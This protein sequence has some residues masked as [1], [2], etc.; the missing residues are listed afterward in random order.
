MDNTSCEQK[1]VSWALLQPLH[2]QP[3]TWTILKTH[4][5]PIIKN[6]C[7][8]CTRYINNIFNSYTGE[9][10]KLN[11]Y[12]T[13]QNM[14]HDLIKFKH[15]KSTHLI[16]FLDTLT[17]V[18]KST[19]LQTTLHTK[20]TNIHNY[21]PNRPSLL[22]Y[23]KESL[24]L[25]TSDYSEENL[26]RRHELKRE[27]NKLKLQYIAWGHSHMLIESQTS[28]AISTPRQDT[29]KLR[30]KVKMNCI[31][32]V[33]TFNNTLLPLLETIKNHWDILRVNLKLK[34]F[35]QEPH[36]LTYCWPNNLREMIGSCNIRNN[37]GIPQ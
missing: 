1:D 19:Q 11:Y 28:K 13:N 23:L 25:L 24:S 15:E 5:Y 16:A 12:L 26:H 32:Y 14:M 6:D 37:K 8:F 18:N 33:T 9:E 22:I 2:T 7:L 27:S 34:Y 35:V 20:P 36:I 30:A 4:T 17:Y 3:S 10:V 29:L 21:L 31:T